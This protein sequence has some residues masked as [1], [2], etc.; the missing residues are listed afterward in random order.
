MNGSG[1]GS[2]WFWPT[3]L[4]GSVVVLAGEWFLSTSAF[5]DEAKVVFRAGLLLIPVLVGVLLGRAGHPPAAAISV[6]TPIALV[7]VAIVAIPITG[8]AGTLAYVVS[9]GFF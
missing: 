8:I 4:V 3:V 5:A 9:I 2:R 1:L 7:F 6:A